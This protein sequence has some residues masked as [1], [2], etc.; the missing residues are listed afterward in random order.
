MV[1]LIVGSGNEFFVTI[2]PL[3]ESIESM[4]GKLASKI[5]NSEGLPII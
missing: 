2:H 5:Y 3:S 1:E 4:F